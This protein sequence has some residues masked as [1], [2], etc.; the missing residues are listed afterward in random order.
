MDQRVAPSVQIEAAI[1]AVLAGGLGDPDALSQLGRLGTQLVLQR[2]VEEEVTAFLHRAR[3]ERTAEA[4]GSRNGHRPRRLQTAEGELTVA[5]PQV[6]GTLVRFVSS[7]IPDTR[8]IIRTRPLEAL[9]I[10]AS[11]RGPSDRDIE[12][13][14][15]EAG[16]GTISKSAM[17]GVCREL[18]DRDRAFRAAQPGRDPPPLPDARRHLPARP[19]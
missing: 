12:R 4:A 5:M 16:L 1:E 8:T 14:A 17:S 7:V 10:G 15:R 11:V 2:A 6:R 9:V 3:Y 19:A 18:R 13:L